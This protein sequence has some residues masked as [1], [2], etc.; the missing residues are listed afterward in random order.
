MSCISLDREHLP[1]VP[2]WRAILTFLTTSPNKFLATSNLF[3]MPIIKC[4]QECCIKR[5]I[6]YITFG[7]HF[8]TQFNSLEIHPGCYVSFLLTSRY[9]IIRIY[10]SFNLSHVDG[11][12][13]CFQ[14]G[15]FINKDATNT[16]VQVSVWIYIFINRSV[17]AGLYG[18]C[19]FRFFKTL[20][21]FYSGYAILQSH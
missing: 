3:S 6:L 13:G 4:F 15:A 7:I 20:P 21:I 5:I 18:S 9:Y 16:G 8:F 12:L 19:K 17:V 1:H 14:F 11:H 10:Y 2:L